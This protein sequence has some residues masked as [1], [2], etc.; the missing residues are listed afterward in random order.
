M[1]PAGKPIARDYSY[2][3]QWLQIDHFVMAVTAA[4]AGPRQIADRH[5]DCTG[6]S[7]MRKITLFAAATAVMI[8]TCFGVWAAAPTS[9]RVTPSMSHQVIEP[10]QIMKNAKGL[11][12]A[13]FYDHG[14]VFH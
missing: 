10:L 13:E 8:A 6:E 12:T 2:A 4:K 7:Q 9:A 1:N 14:F 11:A 3:S 5:A